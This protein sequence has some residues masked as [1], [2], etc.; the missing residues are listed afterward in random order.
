MTLTDVD[1]SFIRVPN[2]TL[3]VPCSYRIDGWERM[4]GQEG[5]RRRAAPPWLCSVGS[6]KWRRRRQGTKE[7]KGVGGEG[8]LCKSRAD[9]LTTAISHKYPILYHITLHLKTPLPQE[10]QTKP[11]HSNEL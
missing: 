11:N 6:C 7:G 5:Q 9:K 8:C 1:I 2:R 4:K 10:S 3:P